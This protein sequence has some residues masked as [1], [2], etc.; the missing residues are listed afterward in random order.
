MSSMLVTPFMCSPTDMA[1]DAMAALG[2]LTSYQPGMLVPS[3]AMNPPPEMVE[4]TGGFAPLPGGV[5]VMV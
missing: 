3:T 5:V 4:P 1:P 2:M